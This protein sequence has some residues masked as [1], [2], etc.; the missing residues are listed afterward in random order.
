[1]PKSYD[2]EHAPG[3]LREE[4]GEMSRDSIV[5]APSLVVAILLLVTELL[6]SQQR[7]Q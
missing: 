1:M 6:V 7:R 3:Y 2:F 5:L 4:F